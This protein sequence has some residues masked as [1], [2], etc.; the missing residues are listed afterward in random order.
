MHQAL[1]STRRSVAKRA[2]AVLALVL[3]AAGGCA[4]PARVFPDAQD[5]H[6]LTSSGGDNGTSDAADAVASDVVA[7]AVV[8]VVDGGGGPDLPPLDVIAADVA[9]PHDSAIPDAVPADDVIPV[10]SLR[11]LQ[12]GQTNLT[13]A[14]QS[15]V[16]HLAPTGDGNLLVVMAAIGSPSFTVASITDDA[17]DGNAYVSTGQRATDSIEFLST[18][19]WYAKDS[20]PGATTVTVNLSSAPPSAQVWVLEVAGLST[21]AP[22]DTGGVATDRSPSSI[23][24]APAVTPSVPDA[25][26]VSVVIMGDHVN[27]IHSGNPFTALPNQ[28]GNDAAYLIASSSGTYGASWDST[29]SGT[30]CGSTAA[31]K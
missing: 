25:L 17:A 18:E 16:V 15:V 21:T 10:Q 13:T 26:V 28:Y 27:G 1:P 31:F 24:D 20:K 29:N 4:L 23:V 12:M 3:V 9:P 11:I 8:D 22:Y 2:Q 14:S 19:I 7:D 6:D 30:F 5:Q